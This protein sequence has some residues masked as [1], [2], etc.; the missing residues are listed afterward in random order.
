MKVA[1]LI[2]TYNRPD[3]LNAVL[4]SAAQ[5][6]RLPDEVII[7]DD[8]SGIHTSKVVERWGDRLPIRHAWMPDMGF[9]AARS[10]NLGV[11]CSEAE[12]IIFID[13]DCL[14][15]PFFISE[16]VALA[17]PGYLL[18]G[19]RQL[20]TPGQT[21]SFFKKKLSLSSIFDS[22]KFLRLPLG[23][24]RDCYPANWKSVRTC[25][26]SLYKMDI[27]KIGGFD[28]SYVGWGREDSDFVIR[29][30]RSGLSIRW[31]R[32]AVCVAHLY[33]V[34]SPRDLLHS[35]DSYFMRVLNDDCQ[36]TVSRS[37]I[38]SR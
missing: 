14:L 34:E 8:G 5:Q 4:D 23:W 24:L 1:L 13:G 18:S 10:R 11:L 15:P 21:K 20:L 29:A 36:T 19:G 30:L 32:L 35:N 22:I 9:R 27:V 25:N 6:C 16:H 3:A 17:R 26:M 37:C 2:T 12:I 31:G 28:E 38:L 7:C 33:H